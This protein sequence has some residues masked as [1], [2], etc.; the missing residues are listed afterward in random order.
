MGCVQFSGVEEL[1]DCIGPRGERVDRSAG[2]QVPSHEAHHK[3]ENEY[4]E[5]RAAG[6]E[7]D[8]C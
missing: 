6:T 2:V 1:P 7:T 5:S 4:V 8:Q 3:A